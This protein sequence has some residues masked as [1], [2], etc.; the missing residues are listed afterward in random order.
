MKGRTAKP[1]L[2][3][4]INVQNRQERRKQRL[5]E[6][7]EKALHGQFLRETESTD[8]GNRWQWLKQGELKRETES[9]L[10]QLSNRLCKLM[11]SN[12]QFIRQAIL[13]YID[14]VKKR[15]SV[16][17]IMSACSILVKRQYRKRHDKV[18][19]YVHFFLRKKHDFQCSNKW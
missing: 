7:K 10:S 12:T 9:L 1:K 15:Q 4:F 17:H 5:I 11:P 3:K 2:K 6:W 18:E 13:H 14:S 19:T 8:D 16:T